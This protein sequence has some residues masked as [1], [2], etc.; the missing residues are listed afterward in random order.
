MKKCDV[1]EQKCKQCGFCCKNLKR[2]SIMLFPED[3]EKLCK[4][5]MITDKMFVE[6]YCEYDSILFENKEIHVCYLKTNN[7]DCPFLKDNLC[8][9]H[10]QKPIQCKHTPYH[11]FS[12][13]EIWGYMPC[14]NKETYPEGNSYK[15]DIALM[16]KFIGECPKYD[17]H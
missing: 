1:S 15:D 17:I 7:I 13:Y 10:L 16:K 6:N 2:Y 3:I 11:F 8:T 5:L 4:V 14:V 12:F 9:V